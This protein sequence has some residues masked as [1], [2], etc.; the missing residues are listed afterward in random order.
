M[1]QEG[2]REPHWETFQGCTEALILRKLL[3]AGL[4]THPYQ[5][6]QLIGLTLI[7]GRTQTDKL[8]F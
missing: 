8:E 5:Q 4:A 2:E 1:I 6:L 7:P 3:D